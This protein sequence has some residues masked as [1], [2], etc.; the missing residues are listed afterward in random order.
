[1]PSWVVDFWRDKLVDCPGKP[2]RRLYVSR[3]GQRRRL[4][5]YHEIKPLLDRYGFE[6]IM[7]DIEP[8]VF[9]EAAVVVGEYGAGLTDIVFCRPGTTVIELTPPRH[10]LPH[11]Y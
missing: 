5:N 7:G 8:S 11:F 1:A 4:A 3:R 10:I 6:E 9:A 2:F